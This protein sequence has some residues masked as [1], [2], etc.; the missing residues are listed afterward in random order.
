MPNPPD[1]PADDAP[2]MQ[3]NCN[4][5]ASWVNV[6][7]VGFNTSNNTG[8]Y[9]KVAH[10][11]TS[12]GDPS[13]I[14]NIGQVYTKLVGSEVQLFYES[15]SGFIAQ[16]T[17]NNSGAQARFGTNTNYQAN[18]AGGWTFL[19]GN[20]KVNYGVF[21]LNTQPTDTVTLASA[22][23]S[24]N[25]IVLVTPILS[26]TTGK[27]WGV[28]NLNTASFTLNTAGFSNGNQFTFWSIGI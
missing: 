8:G 11:I 28:T 16:L 19:P 15:N 27:T 10:F 24:S 6:D 14:A 17:R 3:V 20:V 22:Y 9:H 1:D 2:L 12:A 23:T 13:L 21:T 18:H 5:I 25:F 7:H 4:S 26:A